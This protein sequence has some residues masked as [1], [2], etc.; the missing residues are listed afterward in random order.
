MYRLSILLVAF[1]RG[2]CGGGS[3]DRGGVG[4]LCL[5]RGEGVLGRRV[6]GCI[7][8]LLRMLVAWLVEGQVL[9]LMLDFGA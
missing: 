3:L 6:G 8:T 7:G 9:N 5:R 2:V 1:L 4:R